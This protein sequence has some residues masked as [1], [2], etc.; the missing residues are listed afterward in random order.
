[1]KAK[2]SNRITVIPEQ[3]FFLLQDFFFIIYVYQKYTYKCVQQLSFFYSNDE[4][5][6]FIT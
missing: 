5:I 1:M 2:E 4:R 6:Y 3:P